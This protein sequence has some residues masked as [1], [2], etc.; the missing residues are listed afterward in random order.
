VAPWADCQRFTPPAGTRFLCESTPVEQRAGHDAYIFR[1][2][3]AVDAYGVAGVAVAL[4]PEGAELI[5]RWSRASI[6]GQ[7]L[8]YLRAVAYES[9]RPVGPRDR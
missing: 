4:P 6:L 3:P 8:H 2:S 1:S 7:P 5:A 9:R